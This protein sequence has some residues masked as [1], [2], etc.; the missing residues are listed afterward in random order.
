MLGSVVAGAS[1]TMLF[2]YSKIEGQN[3]QVLN[4]TSYSFVAS[5]FTVGGAPLDVNTISYYGVG[6]GGSH[7]IAIYTAKSSSIGGLFEP[8]ALVATTTFAAA[9]TAFVP[10]VTS[11]FPSMV[12]LAANANYYVVVDGTT[13]TESYKPV[14][15]QSGQFTAFGSTDATPQNRLIAKS[16]ATGPWASVSSASFVPYQLGVTTVSAVPEPSSH[17]ALLALGSAGIL[18]RRRMK[19]AA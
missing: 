2:G 16:N 14:T 18:T 11:Y 3:P 8:D 7:N 12:T 1:T 13:A 6:T 15:G 9:G 10:A 19:R 17:L 5:R 4:S